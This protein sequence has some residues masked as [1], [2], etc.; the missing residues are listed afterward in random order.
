MNS[1]GIVTIHQPE[2]VPW[3][4]FFNKVL[5]SDTVILLDNVQFKKNHFENRNK[6]RIKNEPGWIWITVPVLIKD[7]F[8]QKIREVE[9]NSEKELRWR[10]II[11]NT[12]KQSYQRSRFFNDIYPLV[13]RG[14]SL[15][16]NRLAEIN[17]LFLSS[18]F[19]SLGIKKKIMLQS[20]MNST[21]SGTQLLVDLIKES[22][23]DIYLSGKSGREY[24][25]FNIIR[26]SN[27]I[28]VYQHFRHPIYSQMQGGFIEGMSILD[29]LFNYGKESVKFISDINYE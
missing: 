4:G 13:E 15:N 22:G 20:A 12:I 6:V 7:R 18:I 23:C 28:V 5:Q 21:S 1:K 17:I 3:L 10:E 19:E 25:D 14:I 26:D 11:L 2:F 8:G 24:L 27:I 29:L 9:I 16:T